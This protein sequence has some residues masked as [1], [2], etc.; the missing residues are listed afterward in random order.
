MV[1]AGDF[2]DDKPVAPGDTVVFKQSA[3]RKGLSVFEVIGLITGAATVYSIFFR[4]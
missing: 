3:A 2:S 1:K 4:R